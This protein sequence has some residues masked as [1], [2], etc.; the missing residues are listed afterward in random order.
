MSHYATRLGHAHLKVCDLD[1]SVAFYTTFL[2]LKIVER[3]GDQYAFLT[4][5]DV[6]HELALNALGPGAPAPE[7]G[8]VGLFHIAF[9][10]ATKGAFAQAFQRLTTA[11]I[12]VGP[13]DHRISW[14]LYFDDP[15][16]NGLEIYVD[17]RA[18]PNGA[19]LW[20]GRNRPLTEDV[21]LGHLPAN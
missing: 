10:V 15:D 17:T 16:G 2:S 20:E 3:V 18:E 5:G 4:D 14:A 11:G 6:H 19:D 12:S 8:R 13:V 21:I 7:A 9:E 1:R